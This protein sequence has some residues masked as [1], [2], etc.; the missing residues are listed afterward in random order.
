MFKSNIIDLEDKKVSFEALYHVDNYFD[1]EIH[2]KSGAFCGA[3]AFCLSGTVINEFLVTLDS[4]S[5]TLSGSYILRDY[6]SDAHIVI[7]MLK[8]GSLSIT[9]Q[10]GGSTND[11]YLKFCLYSD[12]TILKEIHNFFTKIL[13]MPIS[14]Q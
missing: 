7:T 5:T 3:S 10:I 13:L 11:Q 6:D 1:V 14:K 8:Y 12:Q 4:L 2:I 9:G